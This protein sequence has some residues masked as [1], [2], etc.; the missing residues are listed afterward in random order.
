MIHGCLMI[1]VSFVCQ[2][3]NYI[4]A[5]TRVNWS[6][7]KSKHATIC[8]IVWDGVEEKTS[9]SPKA[10]QVQPTPEKDWFVDAFS[11]L[12]ELNQLPL[13]F[14]EVYP[15]I[16][17]AHQNPPGVVS[18]HQNPSVLLPQNVEILANQETHN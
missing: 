4:Q 3:Y 5:I 13:F 18:T 8:E 2:S 14:R 15:Q 1:F 7:L 6:L 9:N 10:R 17:P 11:M 12:K 16:H